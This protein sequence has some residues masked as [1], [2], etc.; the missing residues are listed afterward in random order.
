MSTC[1][2]AG[3]NRTFVRICGVGCGT[4]CQGGNT[5]VRDNHAYQLP[6]GLREGDLVKLISFEC[7]YWHCEKDGQMF[8]VFLCCVESGYEYEVWAGCW[9]PDD[10]WRVKAV[11]RNPENHLG[12][13]AKRIANGATAL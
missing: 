9:L 4:Q 3:Q 11:L 5:Q 13:R 8:R 12:E 10:D 1:L 2:G 7:G 6:Q